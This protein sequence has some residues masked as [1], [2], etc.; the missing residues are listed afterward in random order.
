MFSI[1]GEIT[2]QISSLM[3]GSTPAIAAFA[4][5][6]FNSIAV[7]QLVMICIRWELDILDNHHWVRLHLSD[8]V[9]FL[10]RLSAAGILLT[11]YSS[12]LPGFGVSFHQLLPAI[13]QTLAASI[14]KRGDALLTASLNAAV[15]GMPTPSLLSIIE[16][17]TYWIVLFV[18]SL[19]QLLLFVITAF[20]FIAVAV[21][22]LTGYL[23]IPLLLT[24]NFSRYFWTWIDQMVVY[25]MYPFIGSAFVFVLGNALN[26]FF[27]KTFAGGY[28][29]PQLLAALPVLLVL[30]GTFA[31]C[32]FRI[33]QF[34]SQHFGGAGSVYSNMAAGAEE[35]FTSKLTVG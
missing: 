30:L 5:K 16:I 2:A 6:I 9:L 1:L 25:S 22:S 23:M 33:P 21:L 26:N 11:F 18:V 7:F 24:K 13:G 28:T 31:F 32:V 27:V 29:F 35:Y 4:W 3:S 10:M 34:T 20:G 14:D 19:F 12:P 8:V 17:A 15:A